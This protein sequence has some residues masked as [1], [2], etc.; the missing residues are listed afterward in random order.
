GD[1]GDWRTGIAAA[2]L[3]GRPL[4]APIL[5]AQD[6]KLP[7]A[8]SAALDALQPTGAKETGG[9]QVIR[10][11]TTAPVEGYKTTDVAPGAPAAVAAAV[12]RLRAAAA[13]SPASDVVVAST[14]RPEYA[15]PAAAWAAKSGDPVSGVAPDDVPPGTP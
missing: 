3:V 5:F 1:V 6:D 4:R 11:G 10:V 7:D 15:Y 12:D 8:T 14:D 9:A 2:V 13:G